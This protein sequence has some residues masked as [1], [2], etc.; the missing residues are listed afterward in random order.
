[1]IGNTIEFVYYDWDNISSVIHE[2]GEP[3]KYIGL[4]VDAYTEITGKISGSNEIF[5]GFGGGSTSGTTNS[6]RM[7]K[8]QFYEDWDTDKKYIKYK[9]IYDWQLRKII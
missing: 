2:K 5:L 3:K 4:V 1:M 9:D 8:V 7:Y 6:K